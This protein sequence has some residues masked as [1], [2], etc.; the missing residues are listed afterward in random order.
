MN[1]VV[2]VIFLWSHLRQISKASP[3]LDLGRSL[4]RPPGEDFGSGPANADFQI[5]ATSLAVGDR[6]RPSIKATA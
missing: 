1:Y 5:A 4:D 2:S 6:E 3:G